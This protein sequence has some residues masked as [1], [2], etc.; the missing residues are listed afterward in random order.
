MYSEDQLCLKNSSLQSDFLL[1]FLFVS[2]IV[3]KLIS[4]EAG[5]K[6]QTCPLL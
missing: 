3:L 1:A 4:A 5:S 2:F 6:R